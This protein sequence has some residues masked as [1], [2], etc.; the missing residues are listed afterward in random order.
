MFFNLEW[1]NKLWY[2]HTM[3]Y[4]VI[5]RNKLLINAIREMNIKCI[6]LSERSLD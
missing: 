6:V 2:L 5:K 3:D 1:I 4:S